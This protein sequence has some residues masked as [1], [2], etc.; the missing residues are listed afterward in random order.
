MARKARSI[1]CLALYR[2]CAHPDM[3]TDSLL[4]VEYLDLDVF[5]FFVFGSILEKHILE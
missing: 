4:F 5:F 3:H 2:K 1:Y